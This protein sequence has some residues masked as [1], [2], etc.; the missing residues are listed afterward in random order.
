MKKIRIHQLG[1]T[2]L[3]VTL[4]VGCTSKPNYPEIFGVYYLTDNQFEE[5]KPKPI[6]KEIKN[7]GKPTAGEL[8]G[9]R[10]SVL[11]DPRF[12]KNHTI[13]YYFVES[14]NSPELTANEFNTDGFV[15]IGES[16]SE[17]EL[18]KIPN[19]VN[20]KDNLLGKIYFKVV[21][22]WGKKNYESEEIVELKQKKLDNNIYQVT[23]DVA[24]DSGIYLFR[25]KIN[26][27]KLNNK[28]IP[29]FVN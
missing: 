5:I 22:S 2:L 6:D 8:G 13:S 3:I 23:P 24:I 29:F 15:I 19:S 1:I 14:N 7:F 27:Q 28:L 4:I 12:G 10:M 25:Y 18:I 16:I 11:S 9:S 26:G 17:C 21:D 20:K